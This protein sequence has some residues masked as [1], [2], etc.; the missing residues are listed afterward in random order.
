MHCSVRLWHEALEE[1]QGCQKIHY[2]KFLFLFLT[3]FHAALFLSS[4]F[5]FSYLLFWGFCAWQFFSTAGFVLFVT[6]FLPLWAPYP[7]FL[8]LGVLSLVLLFCH[9]VVCLT[10][11]SLS[12][13]LSH[14][15]QNNK[16]SFCLHSF[17]WRYVVVIFSSR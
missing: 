9:A 3:R 4:C 15:I 13:L 5:F 7:P 17:T 2:L 1:Q 12:A 14:I 11:L 6:L 10:F 16:F 8:I